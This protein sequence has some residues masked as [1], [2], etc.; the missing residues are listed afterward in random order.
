MTEYSTN[1]MLLLMIIIVLESLVRAAASDRWSGVEGSSSSSQG[2]AILSFNGYG[3][4]Q[5]ICF[6]VSAWVGLLMNLQAARWLTER[7]GKFSGSDLH[8]TT[9]DARIAWLLGVALVVE[10]GGAGAKIERAAAVAAD[11][12]T[13][14]LV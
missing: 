2:E 5:Q 11:D 10:E 9:K 12:T 6:G 14:P 3:R 7:D 4:A 1:L 13:V 8:E